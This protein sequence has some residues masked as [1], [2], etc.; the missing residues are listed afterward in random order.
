M[1]C[2]IKT[3]DKL[4]MREV[5]GDGA[6][7]NRAPSRREVFS[8]WHT[9]RPSAPPRE[10]WIRISHSAMACTFDAIVSPECEPGIGAAQEY[11][12]S[13]DRLESILSVFRAE[14]EVSMLNR[15]AAEHPVWVGPELFA[16]LQC[17][18]RLHRE[19]DG[20]FDVTSGALTRCWGF[21][22]RS[23]ALPSPEALKAAR[24]SSGFRHVTLHPDGAVSFRSAGL[25][26]NFCSIGKG[27]ALDQG[28][29]TMRARGVTTA[30]LSAA[31]SSAFALGSGPGGAGWRVGLRH[32]VFKNQRFATLLLRSCA[33]GTSGQ[34]EQGFEIDGQRYGH[35]LDPRSG[36]PARGVLSA[37]VLAGS[38]AQSD[39]LATAFFVG[40]MPLAER[41][42]AAHP[43]IVA[44]MLL[45]D[46]LSRPIVVG[47]SNHVE[48]NLGNI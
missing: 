34:E 22:N 30:L 44:V 31:N 48:V 18:E 9:C 8:R 21:E 4:P 25:R 2:S 10:D 20:A 26:I 12:R 41:Y 29:A 3:K 39:A 45:E 6:M 47:S 23:P 11:L 37:T 46:D 35:I 14:S 43:G 15:S 13:V 7:P 32:P 38:A 17:C 19:T 27:Y 42:C 16:L 36:F 5:N 40:G 1:P 33:L 28:A 24:G